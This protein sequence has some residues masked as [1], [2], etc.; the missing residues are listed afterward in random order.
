MASQ[1][2]NGDVISSEHVE[3]TQ[4]YSANTS[5]NV[6]EIHHLMID[7]KSGRVA[8]A[9]MSFG[10]FLGLGES[11]YPVPWNALKYDTNLQGFVTGITAEQLKDAP[12]LADEQSWSDREWGQR[13]HQHYGAPTYWDSV[14]GK[15]S[16]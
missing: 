13:L 3:G 16:A 2:P 10:G 1:S 7:K 11:Y 12:G 8:Y 6:G 4:V 14:A 15:L 9:V 5:E